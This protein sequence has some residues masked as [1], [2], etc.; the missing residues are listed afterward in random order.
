MENCIRFKSEKSCDPYP[1]S[2][3]LIVWVQIISYYKLDNQDIVNSFV[4][5]YVSLGSSIEFELD[6]NH[7]LENYI[8]LYISANFLGLKDDIF[9][10]EK[11]LNSCVSTQFDCNGLHYERSFAYH[12]A[13]LERLIIVQHISK[14]ELG[15]KLVSIF[16]KSLNI[17]SKVCNSDGVPLF[18]DASHD[19]YSNVLYLKKILSRYDLDSSVDLENE[20]NYLLLSHKKNRFIL[21]IGEVSPTFQ[22]AHYHC[23]MTSYTVDIDNVPLIVD[24]GVHGY[25]EDKYRR[26]H[27]RKTSSHNV[28]SVGGAE[29]SNIWS[30]F[31]LGKSAKVI[32]KDSSR[33][34]SVQII[35]INYL[36]FPRLGWVKCSRIVIFSLD[37]FGLIV[38]DLVEN[39]KHK[40]ASN[41][42]LS[43]SCSIAKSKNIF[44]ISSDGKNYSFYSANIVDVVKH[45]VYKKMGVINHTSKLI[46]SNSMDS[47]SVDVCI[48]YAIF[49]SKYDFKYKIENNIIS[50]SNGISV[51]LI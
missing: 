49:D 7:I 47:E 9:Y 12:F 14:G 33:Q 2:I 29:Q 23:S 21:D 36:S 37:F 41:V 16:S 20:S 10:Y 28:L 15:E 17:L 30:V 18:H 25:Y 11:K 42:V 8:A 34:D 40:A 38:V 22:P 35:R 3:R 46:V 1:T 4:E 43:P 32:S 44:E 48:G 31:R 51:G 6:G 27:S 5:Q 13:I 24:T 26:L 45:E 19:M 39:C 50:I